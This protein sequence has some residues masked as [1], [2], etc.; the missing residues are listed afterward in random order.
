MLGLFKEA[1]KDPVEDVGSTFLEPSCGNGNFLVAVLSRKMETIK[2]T[3][4]D[5]KDRQRKI[6]NQD[7]VEFALMQSVASLYGIDISEENVLEARQRMFYDVKDFYANVL[8]TRKPKEGFWE[9]IQWILQKNIVLGDMLS[10]ME[11][12]VLVEYTA[13]KKYFFKRREFRLS[14]M[15]PKGRKGGTLFEGK[16]ISLKEYK[17][18]HY[19]KLC[20]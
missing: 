20:F 4:A 17:P 19:L 11:D 9:G 16:E 2:K 8:N 14:E 13:P 3:Y 1:W 18:C 7:D 5:K 15:L 12:I 6:T 10:H